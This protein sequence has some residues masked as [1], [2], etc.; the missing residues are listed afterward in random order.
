MQNAKLSE[1]ERVKNA[2]THGLNAAC[3]QLGWT[4]TRLGAEADASAQ[5]ALNWLSG[6]AVPSG[7][8][9][10]LLMRRNMV[11]REHLLGAA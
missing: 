5:A 9:L 2:I 6:A 8:T 1:R 3:E 10:V 4:P 7:D 11:V